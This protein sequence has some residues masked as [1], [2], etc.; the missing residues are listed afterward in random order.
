MRQVWRTVRWYAGGVFALCLDLFSR[1]EPE[2]GVRRECWRLRGGAG[3]WAS[4]A[5]ALM[6]ANRADD[7]DTLWMMLE[8]G[9]LG[10]LGY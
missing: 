4:E 6:V 10:Y 7:S 5:L 2:C 1:T 3:K 8:M 9:Y